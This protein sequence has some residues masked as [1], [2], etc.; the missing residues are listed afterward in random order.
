MDPL[1]APDRRRLVA[2]IADRGDAVHRAFEGNARLS[3][4]YRPRLQREPLVAGAAADVAAP[5][6]PNKKPLENSASGTIALFFV[7]RLRLLCCH[8]SG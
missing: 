3:T 5:Q 1:T 4:G 2:A 8:R 7:K 6:S